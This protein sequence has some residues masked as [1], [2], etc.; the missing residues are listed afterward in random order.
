MKT[1]LSIIVAACGLA[2][3]ADSTVSISGIGEAI[4]TCADGPA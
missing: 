1:L 3:L 4:V 2:A